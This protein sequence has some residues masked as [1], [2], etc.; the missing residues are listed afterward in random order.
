MLSRFMEWCFSSKQV[1][2][3]RFSEHIL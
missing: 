3:V 1:S 2:F